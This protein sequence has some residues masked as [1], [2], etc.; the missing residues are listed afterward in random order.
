[1]GPCLVLPYY[2]PDGKPMEFSVEGQNEKNYGRN[3]YVRLKP[4]KPRKRKDGD[5][6]PRKYESP[7][8]ATNRAC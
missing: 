2:T 7:L 1:M 6:D 5:G 4:T 3:L 8:N